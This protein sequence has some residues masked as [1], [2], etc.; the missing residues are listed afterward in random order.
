[1]ESLGEW[2]DI[3]PWKSRQT[4]LML[5]EGEEGARSENTITGK[6]AIVGDCYPQG[7]LIIAVWSGQWATTARVVSDEDYLALRQALDV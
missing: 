6:R 7:A 1:M 4:M 5:I 2:A 3:A